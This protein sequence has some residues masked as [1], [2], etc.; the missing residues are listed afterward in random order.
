MIILKIKCVIE[1]EHTG[2]FD[3][4]LFIENLRDFIC[5]DEQTYFDTG[6][7]TLITPNSKSLSMLTGD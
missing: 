3:E 7:V 6:S 5:E 2:D 4:E 1:L